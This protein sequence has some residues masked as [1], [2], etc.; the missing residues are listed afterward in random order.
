MEATYTLDNFPLFS[1]PTFQ[2]FSESV[3]HAGL[4]DEAVAALMASEEAAQKGAMNVDVAEGG[5]WRDA[6]GHVLLLRVSG[7]ICLKIVSLVV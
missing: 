5:M 6:E 2:V 7:M 1:P 4:Q 3:N